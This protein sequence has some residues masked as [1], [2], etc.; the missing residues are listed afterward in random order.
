VFREEKG[1]RINCGCFSGT[2]EEFEASVNR[3]HGD[4]QFGME[5]R[6]MIE[7]I[8]IRFQLNN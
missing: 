8:K 5:Y 1:I 6:A 4:N 7:L 2:I 3:K